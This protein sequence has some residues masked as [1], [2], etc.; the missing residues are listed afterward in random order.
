MGVGVV[1]RVGWVGVGDWVWVG[2]ER[3]ARKG[4]GDYLEGFNTKVQRNPPI[5]QVQASADHGAE[6]EG[7]GEGAEGLPPGMTMR[8]LRSSPQP[9]QFT[10]SSPQPWQST[11]RE[12]GELGLGLGL[13]IE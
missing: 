7:R 10:C 11:C 4:R 12:V 1:G 5:T 2:I 6:L 8:I 9:W 13:G 3:W